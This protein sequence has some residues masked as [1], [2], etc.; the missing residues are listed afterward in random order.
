V[1][2]PCFELQ[3][4]VMAPQGHPIF[5]AGELTLRTLAEF[6]LVTLDPAT[7][8]GR[9]V[10][11]TFQNAGVKANVVLTALDADVVKSYV[12]LGLG[13]GILPTPAYEPDKDSG[14]RMRDAASLFP[15]TEICLMLRR[16]VFLRDYIV[17]FISWLSPEFDRES[18]RSTAGIVSETAS[19]SADAD[20]TRR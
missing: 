8:G 6:P 1:E 14:L 4:S 15:P 13:I 20:G 3:R 17:D 7:I 10:I 19:G 9:A 5:D 11:G 16:G 12:E 18:V 2:I